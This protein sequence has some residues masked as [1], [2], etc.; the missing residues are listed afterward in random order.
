LKDRNKRK[1]KRFWG[2]KT[3]SDGERARQR[4]RERRCETEPVLRKQGEK[5]AL[6]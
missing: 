4:D 3:K 5:E 6:L 1:E 2:K